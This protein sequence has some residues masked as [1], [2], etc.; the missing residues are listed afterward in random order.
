[1]I[2]YVGNRDKIIKL[3]NPTLLLSVIKFLNRSITK[4]NFNAASFFLPL[5]RHDSCFLRVNVF[6][7]VNIYL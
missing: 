6:F 1:M 4:D 3:A 7:Y 5:H 2:S